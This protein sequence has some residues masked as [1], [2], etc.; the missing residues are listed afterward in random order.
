MQ[1]GAF[2]PLLMKSIRK[3]ITMQTPTPFTLDTALTG[4]MPI[5]RELAGEDLPSTAMLLY[6][7]LLD[8]ATLSQKNRYADETGWVYVIYP[9]ENLAQTFRI[10]TTAVKR[11]L[12]ALEQKKLIHRRRQKGYS[13]SHIFLRLPP[14]SRNDLCQDHSCPGDSAKKPPARGRKVPS[15]DLRKQPEKSNLYYQHGE[16]ESL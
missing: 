10:S 15:N 2:L 8:R 4:Y 14:E 11:N 13:P 1:L 3:G 9:L 12:R 7:A 6:A 5:P 16:D